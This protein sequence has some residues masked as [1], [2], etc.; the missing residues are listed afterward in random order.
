M[1]I[2]G[3]NIHVI[4]KAVSTAIREKD[5]NV[6]RDLAKAQTEAGADYVDLN[7]GPMKKDPEENMQWLVNTV[8]EA[9]DLP[10]SIDTM[11][12]VAMEAGLKA[13]KKRPLLNSASGK[14]DSKAQM[15]PLAKKYNCNVVISVMTD[16]GMPPDV[17]SKIESIMDTVT[18]ANELG[19]PNEDIWVDPIILPVS[20]AGEGQRFTVA[21]LEFIKIL[22]DVLPGVKSTVGLSNVSNG[23]PSDLRPLLNAVYLVMLAKNGLYS[24]IADPLDKDL[25]GLIE[26][27]SPKE[28]ELIHRTMDGEDIDLS[29]LSRKQVEYVKT[30]K[31]LMGET[32]Y[33]DAWLES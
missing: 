6:I 25:M 30:A 1:I 15:L 18:H 10:L 33:S 21:N 27:K 23:V 11:N 16:R 24:A 19:I 3:E 29:T 9:T 31:V 8:Q 7:V 14:T 17:D 28:V 12:P 26:G 32:L 22:E 5:S 4:A 20:T 13:C 2:I